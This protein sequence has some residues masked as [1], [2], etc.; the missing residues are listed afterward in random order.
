[1]RSEITQHIEL[2]SWC[3]VTKA[4]EDGAKYCQI[5]EM[6]CLVLLTV[7]ERYTRG[8]ISKASGT[9]GLGDNVRFWPKTNS[10]A[11]NITISL[12]W[13]KHV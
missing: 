10:G 13:M 9:L 12:V 11:Y 4:F 2:K 3:A 7:V 1:M 5:V 6:A 8:V